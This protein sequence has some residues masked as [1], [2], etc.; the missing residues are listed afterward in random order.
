MVTPIANAPQN[1]TRIA[2]GIIRAPP[3]RAANAPRTAKDSSELTDTATVSD[4]LGISAVTR[5]GM[6]AP[7]EK[8][9][10]DASAA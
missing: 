8:L 1:V 4:P 2:P 10:A 7:T 6:A 9:A 3:A 5:R